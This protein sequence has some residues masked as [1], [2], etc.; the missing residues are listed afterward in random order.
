MTKVVRGK[1]QFAGDAAKWTDQQTIL[2]FPQEFYSG[3]GIHFG[4]KIAFD[5]QKNLLIAVGERGTNMRVQELNNP[6][7]KVFRLRDD[8][9]DLPDNPFVG[10]EGVLKGIWTYGHRNQQGIVF[11]LEGNPWVTE[12]GPR[13]GDEL[14]LLTKGA[15]Y[16]WPVVAFANNYNDTPFRTPW[17]TEEQKITLPVFRWL[18]SIGASGLDVARGKAFPQWQGD[19]LAGGLSGANLDRIRV[20]GGKLVEREEL[21]HGMGRVREVAVGPDGFVYI[22]LNGPDKI[23]RLVPAP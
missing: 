22:A 16:G 8:G 14:N 13:G 2:E 21:I 18:P 9:S 11:D 12:H 15:N 5:K 17:P 3:A 7:G 1:I 19:L 20:K 10:Q 23:I 6:Y 4:C